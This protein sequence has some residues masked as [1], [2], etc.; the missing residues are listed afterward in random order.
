MFFDL[1]KIQNL[2]PPAILDRLVPHR[3]FSRLSIANK[4]LLGYMTLSAL[5]IIV[6]VYALISFQRLNHINKSIVNVDIPVQEAADKMLDALLARCEILDAPDLPFPCGGCFGFW[7]YDLKN[8]LEPKLSR[9]A[10]QDTRL[11]DCHV[12]FYSS[13]VVF[14]HAAQKQWIVSTGLAADGSRGER[15]RRPT[16]LEQI[17]QYLAHNTRTKEEVDQVL[18][19]LFR[20]ELHQ[21]RRRDLLLVGLWTGPSVESF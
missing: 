8:F 7:G 4:M 9:R 18:A 21:L 6:V 20:R 2:V 15:R 3:L 5:T 14:D 12:G 16:T 10:W 17:S 13:L 19:L 11:P 1:S